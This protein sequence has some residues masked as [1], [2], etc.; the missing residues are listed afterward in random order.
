MQGSS[1]GR[2]PGV[3]EKFIAGDPLR[4]V[5]ALMVVTFHV[6]ILVLGYAQ[7]RGTARTA[8]DAFGSVGGPTL[9]AMFLCVY[10]FLTL[11]G[12][13]VGRPF[14]RAYVLGRSQPKI[15]PY[16]RNRLVRIVPLLVITWTITWIVNNGLIHG[17]WDVLRPYLFAQVYAPTRLSDKM[18]HAWTVDVEAVF[19]VVL[20]LAVLLLARLGARGSQW[21]RAW[22]FIVPLL[23]ASA[24]SLKLRVGTTSQPA[25]FQPQTLV[26]AFAPGLI[27]ATIEPLVAPRLRAR[28]EARTLLRVMLAV[29]VATSVATA[30]V[31]IHDAWVHTIA[32]V[33]GGLFV[34]IPLVRQW[35]RA[36]ASRLLD[37]K[38]LHWIG[39]RSYSIYMLHMLVRD[40]LLFIPRDIHS[41][42]PA[43]LLATAVL[44]AIILPVAALS[45]RFIEQPFLRLK[46]V[47]GTFAPRVA[48][49][50]A[51]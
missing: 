33:A 47:R 51:T 23:I 14:L 24:I 18:I 49:E 25:Y 35:A 28:G 9:T 16:A 31:G 7:G 4:A 26:F 20:P 29:L 3:G 44:F 2:L 12:Y 1:G 43:L 21:L 11:S 41:A 42:W 30:W 27:L 48:P 13:L 34:A 39:E 46:K 50:S 45:Y 5:C 36:D 10:V 8:Q 15:R 38:P 6:G 37:A 22:L 17:R 40:R 19:Y 32:G